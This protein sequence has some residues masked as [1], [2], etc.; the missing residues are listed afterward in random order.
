MIDNTPEDHPDQ[1]NLQQ[2]LQ[3]V[4]ALAKAIDESK[5]LA[6]LAVKDVQ[7]LK[8]LEGLID[9]NVALVTPERRFIQQYPITEV[10]SLGK[11]S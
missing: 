4:K 3:T 8:E 2:A 11:I 10:V 9:G 1:E 7:V 5:N 6:D